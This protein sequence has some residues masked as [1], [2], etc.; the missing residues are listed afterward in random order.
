MPNTY[1]NHLEESHAY[2]S[3]WVMQW[4]I[5]TDIQ[6]SV[7]Q[8]TFKHVS[9]RYVDKYNIF[10]SNLLRKCKVK[11]TNTMYVQYIL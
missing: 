2:D 1:T 5:L 10:L 3:L 6:T 4:H 8:N 11:A 7:A 9:V